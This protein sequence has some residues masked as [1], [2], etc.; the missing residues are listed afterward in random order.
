MFDSSSFEVLINSECRSYGAF[1]I[2]LTPFLYL[3]CIQRARIQEEAQVVGEQ[4]L[5]R[6]APLSLPLNEIRGA[7]FFSI[8]RIFASFRWL[9]NAPSIRSLLFNPPYFEILFIDV[10]LNNSWLYQTPIL[11]MCSLD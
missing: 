7:G 2:H 10:I 4:K 3:H 1:I 6:Q 5:C 11:N 9:R 8:S